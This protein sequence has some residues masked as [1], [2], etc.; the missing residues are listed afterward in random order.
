MTEHRNEFTNSVP[1]IA[2]QKK[3][4]YH[5]FWMADKNIPL[6]SL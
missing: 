5:L 4:K 2:E 3:K 6:A 1:S